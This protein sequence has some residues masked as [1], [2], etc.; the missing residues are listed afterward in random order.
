M[1]L[2]S[3]E[4][5]QP[6]VERRS[7]AT[8]I[9]VGAWALYVVIGVA[10]LALG[11]AT[12]RG[13]WADLAD[14]LAFFAFASMGARLAISVPSNGIGWTLLAV[15][16][17][18]VVQS[19]VGVYVAAA[20]QV[21]ALPA[22]TL[23]AWVGTWMGAVSVGAALIVLPSVFP[24]GH[25][26]QGRLGSWVKL[27]LV[28]FAILPVFSAFAPGP[29]QSLPSSEN[30]FGLPLLEPI[31]AG[32][33]ELLPLI[34]VFPIISCA[35]IPVIRFERAG[36]IERAQIKW[37]AFAVLLLATVLVANV[38]TSGA[39]EI[40]LAVAI[41]LVPGAIGVAVL[42]YHLYDI[43]LIINRTLVWVPLT[44]LLGGGYA[45]LVALLQRVFINVTGDKSDA[46]IIISTLVLASLFTPVRR[47]LDS[48]VDSRFRVSSAARA[49]A[50]PD[51]PGAP[52]DDAELTRRMEDIAERVAREVIAEKRASS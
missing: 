25:L 52:I 41:A 1:D 14:T 13:T 27:M 22:V 34:A 18:A 9:A 20:G 47:V 43:D 26:P 12:G 17:T 31:A 28:V 33:R 44:A 29:L 42:R 3:E 48:I 11:A 37:F 8:W 6:A 24:D 45:A 5:V 49:S 21:A 15:A 23:V 46:A 19:A 38:L 7:T 50:V 36:A 16:L 40:P 39:L 32:V 4:L 2:A 35:V 10:T 51:A 30:P